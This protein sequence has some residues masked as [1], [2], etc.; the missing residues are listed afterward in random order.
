M[1]DSRQSFFCKK[2]RVGASSRFGFGLSRFNL[3]FLHFSVLIALLRLVLSSFATM[4]SRG[5]D[6]VHEGRSRNN[7]GFDIGLGR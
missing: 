5:H 3:T 7:F 1:T 6:D 2:E 4:Q